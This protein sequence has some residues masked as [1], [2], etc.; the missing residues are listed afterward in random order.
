MAL[1]FEKLRLGAVWEAI[2]EVRVACG[3]R[4]LSNPLGEIQ[5]RRSGEWHRV[6]HPYGAI[7]GASCRGGSHAST[8]KRRG[9]V[10]GNPLSWLLLARPRY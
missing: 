7:P 5:G 1:Q 9:T 2:P 8:D 3:D 6:F 4:A 10:D